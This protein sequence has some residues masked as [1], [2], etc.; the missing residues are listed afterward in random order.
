MSRFILS[1]FALLCAIPASAYRQE[2]RDVDIRVVL[3]DDGTAKI[4]GLQVGSIT[5]PN[6]NAGNWE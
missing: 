4:E 3:T 6:N 5:A 2:I 1:V